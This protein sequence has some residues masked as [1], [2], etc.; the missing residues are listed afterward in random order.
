[1]KSVEAEFVR[2]GEV[3]TEEKR[4]YYLN[5]ITNEI[6]Q[7]PNQFEKV[8]VMLCL[9]KN[10]NSSLMWAHYADSHKGFIIGFETEHPFFKPETGKSARGLMEIK[11]S[12]KRAV[13]FPDGDALD[14]SLSGNS[15]EE[16]EKFFFTKS[17]EWK[18]EKEFRI[19][20]GTHHATD[21]IPIKGE[22]L[23]L[24]GFSP[25]CVKEVIIGSRMSLEDRQ[26]L[27]KIVHTKYPGAELFESSL[28]E[29]EFDMEI[30]P[31]SP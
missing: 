25:S 11:Y 23:Y 19:Y 22:T 17:I 31:I 14:N 4:L 29:T 10:K 1:M 24:F 7:M 21:K 2:N 15:E 9:S 27:I 8:M 26:K 28:S 18:Y 6:D 12:E 20:A 30:T 3:L 5:L 16:L 13:A